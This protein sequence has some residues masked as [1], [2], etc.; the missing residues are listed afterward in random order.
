MLVSTRTGLFLHKA[1]SSILK[2][3]LADFYIESQSK[4]FVKMH[5]GRNLKFW[6]KI[7]SQILGISSILSATLLS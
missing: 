6:K 1:K 4:R 3:A 2:S 7:Q 5:T